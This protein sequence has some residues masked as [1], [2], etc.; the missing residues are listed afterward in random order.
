[1]HQ[2]ADVFRS[3][4]SEN[5]KLFEIIKSMQNEIDSLKEIVKLNNVESNQ[6]DLI[7]IKKMLLSIA[8]SIEERAIKS[9]TNQNESNE[10]VNS[11]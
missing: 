10:P 6:S 9:N 4:S 7:D 5:E 3:L 8:N 11:I 1:L 2:M